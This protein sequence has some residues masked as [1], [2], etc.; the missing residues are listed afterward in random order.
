MVQAAQQQLVKSAVHRHPMFSRKGMMERLFSF[1]FDSFVYNQIWE[2]PRVDMTALELGSENRVLTIASGG[3]NALN[4]LAASP[5]EIVAVDIN[6][7]HVYLTR[8]KLA[9]L[10]YL[11][12]YEDFFA[13]FGS[14]NTPTNVVLYTRYLS[15]KLDSATRSFWEGGTWLRKKVIGPRINYF[16][17]NF[18]DYAKLG[19]LLRFIHGLCRV[20]RKDPRR[21]LTASTRE[22]QEKIFNE[23]IA[24]F[25]DNRAIK[26]IGRQPLI[27]F[28]LG[29]PPKQ[30]EFLRREMKGDIVELYR[31]RVRRL[32]CDFPIEDNYFTWQAVAR[33]YDHEGKRAL[34]DYLKQAGYEQRKSAV[35]R[36][37]CEIANMTE[38]LRQQPAGAFDRF[39]LLDSQDWME[40]EQIAALWTEIERVGKP[41]TRIVFRSGSSFS[42]VEEALPAELRAKFNYDQEQ[43]LSLIKL[44]RA[45]I[46]GGFHIYT[47]PQ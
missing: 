38:F 32:I 25:F 27:L 12:T 35:G 10:E 15:E 2:D 13:F 17:T 30:L 14:A 3:C 36:V 9:A 46:Y 40:R 45:A 41:G 16:S 19:Y 39:V 47:K 37:R 23:T 26:L 5:A 8:L 21:I 33:R 42:P 1:W 24:P 11:P 4:Y 6:R 34:P 18:Y 28:S 44:D 20:T 29:I 43:S 22:E 31:E 7:Y